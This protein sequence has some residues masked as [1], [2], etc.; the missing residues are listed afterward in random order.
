M[1]ETMLPAFIDPARLIEDMVLITDMGCEP[2]TTFPR[3]LPVFG[4]GK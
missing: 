1:D 2:P 3:D 4:R